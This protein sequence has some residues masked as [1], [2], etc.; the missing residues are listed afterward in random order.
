M[1]L[2][3][4]VWPW[5]LTNVTEKLKT[6][7]QRLSWL[8]ALLF[9]NYLYLHHSLLL[10]LHSQKRGCSSCSGLFVPLLLSLLSLFCQSFP[11]TSPL[12]FNLSLSV[13]L[14]TLYLTCSGL[15]LIGLSPQALFPSPYH[16]VFLFHISC[17]TEWYHSSKIKFRHD[18]KIG[19]CVVI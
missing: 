18:K 17:I 16:P 9:L 7:R 12:F 11:L 14:A 13:T 2:F 1:P 10:L 6:I 19:S 3:L 15:P 8:S 4:Y 5:L